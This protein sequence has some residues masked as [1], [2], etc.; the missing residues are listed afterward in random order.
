MKK[1]KIIV[2]YD[3]TD[4]EG[5]QSQPHQRT[6]TNTL[7]KSFLKIFNE[8]ISILGA[9]RTD[10]G[11]HALGQVATFSTDLKLDL[12]TIITAWNNLLPKDIVIRSGEEI[13]SDFNPLFHVEEK[14]YYYNLFYSKPLPFVARFG[15]HY[16]YLN[17][18][19]FEKL[20]KAL[21]L[22][23]GEH[24][25]RSFCKLDPEETKSTIRTINSISMQKY[26]RFKML[27][28]KIRGKSF[29]RF[30]IRRMV[31]YAL[32]IARKEDL[33]L[34]YLKEIIEKPSP[35]QILTKAEACGLCLRKIIYKK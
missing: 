3:G 31:G 7:E 9:S 14:T 1:I 34:D 33:S 20:N 2:S 26:D 13:Q 25:F 27:Q 6:I 23:I 17:S 21:N 35:I 12:S 18:L 32:D 10:S 15:W 11:V 24:D 22:Y 30:Q 28:I 16:S 4:Y 29:L 19:D 5:W 8:K